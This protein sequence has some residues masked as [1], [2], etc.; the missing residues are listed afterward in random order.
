MTSKSYAKS[1]TA[2][3][4]RVLVAPVVAKAAVVVA[5]AATVVATN[6]WTKSCEG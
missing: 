6:K 2:A 4:S 5:K 1:S 3:K